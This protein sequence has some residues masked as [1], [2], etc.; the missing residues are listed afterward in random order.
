[1]VRNQ[2]VDSR[3]VTK[4]RYQYVDTISNL[5][6]E[7]F[8]VLLLLEELTIVGEDVCGRSGTLFM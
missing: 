3:F 4:Y 7:G 8:S 1:M 6:L 5:L 2:S